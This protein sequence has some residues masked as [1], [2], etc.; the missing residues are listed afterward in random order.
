[1]LRLLD[2]GDVGGEEVN[3]VT[4]EVASGSVVVLGGPGVGVSGEDL[5][6]AKGHP[7]V[8]GVSDCCV[9]Q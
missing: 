3:P 7:G 1:V 2:A 4:V 5:G 6:V 9:S 8:E